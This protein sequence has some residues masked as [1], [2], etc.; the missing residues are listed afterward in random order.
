ML[1]NHLI[2]GSR[3][4]INIKKLGYRSY[5]FFLNIP[6]E[7]AEKEFRQKCMRESFVNALI[8]Y[9]GKWNYEVS[10][11]EASPEKANEKFQELIGNLDIDDYFSCI[12]LETLKS[13]ILP[14]IISTPKI[15]KNIKNDPSFSRQFNE[16]QIKYS[17]D[18]IDREILY[19][20]SQNA[21]INI[22]DIGKKVKLAKDSV[23]YRIKKL[24][25][26]GYI[27]QFRPV[28]DFDS[29][30]LSIQALLLKENFVNPLNDAKFRAYLEKSDKVLWAT[31]LFGDWNYLIY[32][33]N[34]NPE[35]IHGFIRELKREFKE[36]IKSY[37]LIYA[38][39]EYKYGFMAENMVS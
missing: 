16:P 28:I 4:V 6:S 18:N 20:L 8:S 9:S 15:I 21:E 1:K 38:Y 12:L 33:I 30:G 5:H 10:I 7:D 32:I 39:H 13:A 14:G 37:E 19:L 25:R 17:P 3:T 11:M 23:S 22:S 35:E 29:L 26:S 31:K 27:L 2:A 24:I 36:S 34:K